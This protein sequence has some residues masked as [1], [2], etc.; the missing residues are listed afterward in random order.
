MPAGCNMPAEN[1]RVPRDL[2]GEWKMA[3]KNMEG[4]QAGWEGFN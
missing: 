1:R 3:E 4:E 2:S